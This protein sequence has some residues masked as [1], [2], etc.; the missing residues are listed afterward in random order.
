[1]ANQKIDAAAREA[2]LREAYERDERVVCRACNACGYVTAPTAYD[3]KN[4]TQ[5]QACRGFGTVRAPLPDPSREVAALLADAAFG[6]ECR[7]GKVAR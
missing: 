4:T 6:R 2:A 5:C 3:P 1:M 7:S